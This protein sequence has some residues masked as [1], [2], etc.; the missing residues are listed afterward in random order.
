MA[1]SGLPDGEED[2]EFMSETSAAVLQGAPRTA[3]WILW[4]TALFFLVALIWAS[5]A[6]LDEIATGTGKVIPTSHIQ[7][8][9]NLEGG[10][11][12]EIP[13][14]EGDVVQKGQIL[15]QMDAT[16]FTSSFGENQAKYDAL[17]AKIARLSAE[18]N[19]T[20][21]NA[22]KELEQKNQKLVDEEKA[23]YA[24]RLRELQANLSVLRQQS[25]QRV[26]ELAEKR[27][28]L[29][30]L[31]Q[32]HGLVAREV[33]MTRPLVQQGVMSE[34]ELLRL[35]RQQSDLK[36]ELEATR[37]SIPRLEAALMEARNKVE[38]FI[39]KFRSDAM[40]DLSA[41][42][43]EISAIGATSSGLEDRL[44][45][46]T[47]RSPMTGTVKRIK[48]TTIGGVIQPGMDLMEIVPL[49]DNLLIEARVKPSDIAFLRPG[50]DGVVK[51]SA[52]DFSIYG[53][54]PAKLEF[55][56]AD[57]ITNDEGETFYI[58]RARTKTNYL[59]QGD[60][61]LPI[62]PGMLATVDIRTGKKT[63]LAYLL[64]P[65]FKAKDEA[66]RER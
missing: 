25:E 32:S 6:S 54:V 5:L 56:S 63:V 44:A 21:F 41:A 47:V 7:I 23:L 52:Y 46:T 14:R 10:I 65:V 4:G 30:Q 34:V 60:K 12:S 29:V 22:P 13:V 45:R 51:L 15:V 62:I 49:E 31:Q 11:L 39:I 2:A 53:G 16:R 50:L 26:Q 18:A 33:A 66:L 37:I 19:N 3:H 8:V 35:E 40:S 27:A 58:I 59:V 9:Q 55:I 61:R 17:L 48:V 57:S 36:G 38:G 20:E 1:G 42:R 64:K 24:S 43:A 28:R